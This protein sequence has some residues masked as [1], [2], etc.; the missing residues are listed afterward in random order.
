ML[1]EGRNMK[2][3]KLWKLIMAGVVALGLAGAIEMM[4]TIAEASDN[5]SIDGDFSDWKTADLTEGYNGFTALESHGQYLDVYVQ[6]NDGGIPENGNYDLVIADKHY[7]LKPQNLT[8]SVSAGEKKAFSLVAGT[9]SGD[10]Q[11]GTVGTGY[12]GNVASHNVAEFRVDLTKLNL[13][14]AVNGKIAAINNSDIGNNPSQVAIDWTDSGQDSSSVAA[15]GGAI[16]G[17]ADQS[18][19]GTTPTD[20]NAANDNDNLN[21]KIDGKFADWKNVTL[22]EGYNGYTAMVSDGNYV[23]VY[24]KMMGTTLVPGYG[25]YNFDIGGTQYY[26]WTK[27]MPQT[28]VKEGDAT[29]V[30]FTGGKYNEGDQ[31]GTVGDGYVSSDKNGHNIAEFKVDLRKFHLSTM[32]GQTITMY[33]PNIGNEKVT[34]AGGSTGPYVISGIG[35]AIAGLGYWRLKKSGKLN[36]KA[37]K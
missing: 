26:V 29:A 19:K 15:S 5:I 31:Y 24:V 18:S 21:I 30:T 8:A 11:Y 16:N 6:K 27:Q 13:T 4:P 34:V 35:L 7:F 1:F 25:D 20:S 32:T 37:K 23:Y 28:P 22:T 3:M 14:K 17:K 10:D 12:V 2:P 36:R 33:N 9:W